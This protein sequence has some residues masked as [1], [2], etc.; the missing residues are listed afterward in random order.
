MLSSRICPL[1]ENLKNRLDITQRVM[2]RRMVG[3]VSFT[4]D[5]WEERGRKMKCR[6]ER[7]LAN[8]PVEKWST[9]I[10]GKK[11]SLV[12]K[13]SEWPEWTRVAYHWDPFVSSSR[14]RFRV[15]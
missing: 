12:S 10:H 9:I 11:L 13:V 15:K 8:C 6:L 3:W 4:G 14:C 5:T 2:L 1:T 7:A